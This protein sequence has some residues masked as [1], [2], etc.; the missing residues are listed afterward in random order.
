[1][2]VDI[3]FKVKQYDYMSY[4]NVF[5]NKPVQ[6][7]LVSWAISDIILV[8][9]KSITSLW[10]KKKTKQKKKQTNKQTNK[11]TKVSADLY[12]LLNEEHTKLTAFSVHILKNWF[13]Q[14]V[15]RLTQTWL[16]ISSS[17]GVSE[18][19]GDAYPTGAPGPYAQFF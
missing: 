8:S 14:R 7:Y 6:M 1:M 5:D 13:V 11:Q 15:F 3:Y 19:A 16:L 12:K 4:S 18:V 17:A 2:V 9:C 10:K